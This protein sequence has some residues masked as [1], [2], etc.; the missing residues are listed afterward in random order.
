MKKRG[1]DNGNGAVSV[2]DGK[3]WQK[4]REIEQKLEEV[5]KIVLSMRK[6]TNEH[7]KDSDVDAYLANIE[8][9]AI[10]GGKMFHMLEKRLKEIEQS[11]YFFSKDKVTPLGE[12]PRLVDL[13]E[14]VSVD[15]PEEVE[16]Q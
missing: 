15:M 9:N 8:T 11:F 14:D 13:E 6:E 10:N 1:D 7:C 16:S 12:G 4:A 5:C 3:W 2:F